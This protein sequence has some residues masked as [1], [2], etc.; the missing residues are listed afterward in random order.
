[1]DMLAHDG[2]M[3]FE[4]CGDVVVSPKD[5]KIALFCHFCKDLFTYLPEFLRHLQV[6][7]GDVLHFTKEHHVYSVEEL[8][9]AGGTEDQEGEEIANSSQDGDVAEEPGDCEG[10]NN[11]PEIGKQ[12]KAGLR[13]Q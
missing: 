2:Q 7:H 11:T 1:M 9:S 10:T 13:T 3:D 8:L 6:A 4:K 5:N 12:G